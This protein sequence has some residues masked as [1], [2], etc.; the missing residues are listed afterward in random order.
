MVSLCDGFVTRAAGQH[1]IE[2]GQLNSMSIPELELKSYRMN[3]LK[4]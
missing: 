4:E 1:G 3:C 2:V